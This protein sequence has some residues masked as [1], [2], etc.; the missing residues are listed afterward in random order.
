VLPRLPNFSET[1]ERKID[2]KKIKFTCSSCEA[3]LRV[4]THLA[5]VSAPCPKCGATITAPTGLD[6]V[7]DEAPRRK[8]SPTQRTRKA[9]ETASKTREVSGSVL[10]AQREAPSAAASADDP[11]VR[12]I[13][14]A[15]EPAAPVLPEPVAPEPVP[16]AAQ[17]QTVE[18]P[19]DAEPEL[20]VTEEVNLRP[21]EPKPISPPVNTPSQLDLEESAVADSTVPVPKTQPI[22]ITPR[23]DSLPPKHEGQED[24]EE[25]PRLDV[26]LAETIEPTQAPATPGITDSSPTRVQ[27]PQ[28][29]SS[30]EFSPEDFFVPEN[31][32]E[33]QSPA[34][35][36]VSEPD[37]DPGIATE[38]S[39]QL[40]SEIALSE[41]EAT[42][43]ES[44]L[45]DWS[46]QH[47]PTETPESGTH[48]DELAAPEEVSLP[49]ESIE[50]P[51]ETPVP[52]VAESEPQEEIAPDFSFGDETTSDQSAVPPEESLEFRRD[53]GS[54]LQ[55]GSF[56]NLL[57]Q[58]IE[59]E[60]PA[61]QEVAEAHDPVVS[62]DF[63]FSS[64]ISEPAT[65]LPPS[66]PEQM[67]ARTDA[68]VLDEMFGSSGGARKMKKSTVVMLSIIAAVVIIAIVF[69]LMIGK[70]LGGF[71]PTIAERAQGTITPPPA[72]ANGETSPEVAQ[73][74]G[75]P[76]EIKTDIDDAPAIIDPVARERV[77]ANPSGIVSPVM[78]GSPLI[79]EN[80]T[81][82]VSTPD[83]ISPP[84]AG[85]TVDA[86]FSGE[87]RIG[88]EDPSLSFDERLDQSMRN[89]NGGSEPD[90]G[91]SLTDPGTPGIDAGD[92]AL[93][94]AAGG[95]VAALSSENSSRNYN[96]PAAF[97]AP[98]GTESSPL[99][100]THDLLDAFLRAPNWESQIPYIY[101]G[102]SLRPTIEEYYKR[103]SFTTFDRFSLQLFQM[104]QDPEMG[105]PY[106][107]YLVSTS[108]TDQGYPVIIRV[109]NG[110]LKIDWEIYS[111]FQDQHFAQFLKG[112]IASPHT[113][114]VV[115]ERVSDYYGPDRS[116]FSDLQD[117]LVFQIN[118]P[119]GDLGEFSEYAF[120]KRGSEVAKRLDEVVGLG[121]EALAVIVTLEQRKFA[122]GVTH[123]VVTDYVT[124][125]WFR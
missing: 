59:P 17:S 51:I 103:Y 44:E 107:V 124:E 20:L 110:N 63:P 114:R 105:G 32:Q 55:E 47:L 69:V 104:E 119:Y 36:P 18:A 120:V 12:E 101:Q 87:P 2:L 98:D 62:P 24:A 5:G 37:L 9:A 58:S 100:K 99:G 25:L 111:E 73:G 66:R 77:E 49:T 42:E 39:E 16:P 82:A 64:P 70:A 10:T 122:H 22:R 3:K 7:I 74:P 71:K 85:E 93:L 13:P 83:R 84:P 23:S 35:P 14:V 56:E 108:D 8:S 57:S 26:N 116:E 27:L 75:T 67:P 38:D 65:T 72:P 21:P 118:P 79:S 40:D 46:R 53:D 81:E 41:V 102:E 86:G 15:P 123:E 89:I 90:L 115:I 112:S 78:E 125:G 34:A 68:D 113:F 33:V 95:A 19:V 52:P 97:A 80:P 60:I 94:G 50:V 4:P 54:A 45:E 88:R 28:V 61:E 48:M 92:A 31:M 30:S 29:G 109:E 117:Y 76:A 43:Q 91:S 106:W 121:E 6:H 1:V 11:P 96:P